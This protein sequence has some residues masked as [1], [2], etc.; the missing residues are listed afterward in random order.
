MSWV[1]NE[2]NGLINLLL[3]L[4]PGFVAAQFFYLISS[5][6]KPGH[7]GQVIHAL[8]FTVVGQ[9]GGWLVGQTGIFGALNKDWLAGAEFIAT[10]LFALLLA[11]I[12]VLVLNNNIFYN[13]AKGLP[14]LKMRETSYPSEWYAAF[15]ERLDYC[16]VVLHL[17]GD[18]RLLG[19]PLE[20]PKTPTA[21]HFRIVCAV[22]LS[23]A[24]DKNKSVALNEPMLEIVISAED[25][26]MI[27][28]I[29]RNIT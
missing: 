17:S 15:E 20:A 28:F 22:W 5:Y 12:L 25:V 9:G 2:P 14:F 7:F 29:T 23:D 4:M 11:P 21:G 24:D 8:S 13:I 1:F 18:R 10:L 6:P 26:E 19:W 16:W 27:E 3:F